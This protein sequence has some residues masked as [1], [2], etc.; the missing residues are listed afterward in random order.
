MS[1]LARPTGCQRVL[2]PPEISF[3]VAQGAPVQKLVR[4]TELARASGTDAATAL[5]HDGLMD[6]DAFYRALARMLGCTFLERFQ[7]DPSAPYPRILQ[8]GAAPLTGEARHRFVAAPRGPALVSLLRPGAAPVPLTAITSPTRLRQ[9]AFE[10]HA[11]AIAGAASDELAQRFPEWSCRPGAKPMDL[12]LLGTAIALLLVVTNLPGWFALALLAA[13][14]IVVLAMLVIR[15]ASIG[16]EAPIAAPAAG[17]SPR[18]HLLPTYT[19][20][21]ALN[22]EAPVVP[23]LVHSLANLDYPAAKLQIVFVIEADDRETAAALRSG[24][25]MPARFEVV[26]VPPGLPRTKPRALNAALPLA[27]GDLLVVYDAEDTI[28]PRQLRTAANLFAGADDRTACLQGRL[29]IDNI[30]DSLLTR[31]FA[32]EYAGLFDVLNPAL[33]A[34]DLP[35]PLGGTTTHFRT[36]VLRRF[37]GWDAWN[38]TED[39]DLGIRLAAAGYRVG[40]LPSPTFEEAPKD[41]RAWLKQR[42]RWMKGFLQTSFTHG[43][44]PV[45]LFRRLGPAGTLCALALLP[46]TVISALVYPFLMFATLCRLLLGGVE[47]DP[48]WLSTFTTGSAIVVFAVGLAAMLLPGAVGCLRRKWHELLVFVPLMPFYF[49]LV[50]IAAWLAVFE[51]ARHPHRWNKTEHG[52]SRTSRSGALHLHRGRARLTTSS[53]RPPRSR[54]VVARG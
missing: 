3:L 41:L 39:A 14:Q 50:S 49:L 22:K 27:R 16:V 31:L 30:A 23:R 12:A 43:R 11:G 5:L 38:V 36:S 28:D 15:L 9:A 10:S 44:D 52:L 26:V 53:P 48:G 1:I 34:W 29:V 17:S 40:D 37:A 8:A 25:P 35:L 20:L 45:A 47:A 54:P 7:I 33:A 4:A 18:D 21:V 32:I 24:P 51:L 19:V 42:T 13:T 2:L 6:E 46:G